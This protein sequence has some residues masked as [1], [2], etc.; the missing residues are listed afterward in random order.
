MGG[1]TRQTLSSV[2]GLEHDIGLFVGIASATFNP[3]QVPVLLRGEAAAI[4]Q[5]MGRW[6]TRRA[7]FNVGVIF[8]GAGFYGAAMGWWRAPQQALYT[9]IKFPLI[10]L[11][12]ALGNALLNGMLAPLLGLDL[13]FRQSLLAILMSFTIAAAILGAFSPLIFFIV[14][15]TPPLTTEG[16]TREAAYDFI[17]LIQVAAIAFAGVAANLRLGQLL[18]HLSGSATVARRVLVA[19]LAGNLLLGSQLCWIL[20]PFIGTPDLPLQFLRREAFQ[21]NFFEAVFDALRRLLFQ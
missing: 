13:R 21:G 11:L 20:R 2:R 12:T 4:G 6:E 8:L 19:W 18:R 3:G 1:L 16:A 7:L 10:L 15:N 5:W 17:R 14:W 9:A